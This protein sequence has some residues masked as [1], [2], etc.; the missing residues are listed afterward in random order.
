M[1]GMSIART[2]KHWFYQ[3]WQVRKHF[4]AETLATI[5]KKIA[6]SERLHLGEIRFAVE[7]A[8]PWHD[9]FDRISARERALQLFT[10]LRVWDTEYN[11]GVLIYLLL[12]DR[13]V[14]IVADRGIHARV[15]A[16]GWE[17]ICHAMEHEFRQGHF[18][19]SV[20]LG[21][22][23]ITTILREQYPSRRQK[24]LNELPDDPIVV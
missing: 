1:V 6:E 14:E 15:G 2:L 5:N 21:I 8:L 24:N 23:R 9:A 3:P 10:Q 13:D 22:E 20:L 17:A 11:N 16:E 12:A 18:E 19:T 4:P 7:G